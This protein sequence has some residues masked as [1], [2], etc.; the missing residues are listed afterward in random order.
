MDILIAQ[1]DEALDLDKPFRFD[2]DDD[3]LAE[4]W[5][6]ETHPYRTIC[7]VIRRIHETARQPTVTELCKEALLM[8]K[9]MNKRLRHYK[10]DWDRGLWVPEGDN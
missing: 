2:Q 8:A 1:H 5:L 7:N 3:R 10:R 6:G 9:A 4:Q